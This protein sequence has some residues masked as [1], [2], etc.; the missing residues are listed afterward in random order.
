[1]NGKTP[2]VEADRRARR[3]VRSRWKKK[4]IKQTR[5]KK[6]KK[7]KEKNKKKPMT[8]SRNDAIDLLPAAFFF[9]DSSNEQNEVRSGRQKKRTHQNL[10]KKKS[11]NQAK[12]GK[13]GQKKVVTRG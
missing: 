10:V 12:L 2:L 8:K 6:N 3:K 11:L 1:M 5:K 7:E 4:Q 13:L 9:A